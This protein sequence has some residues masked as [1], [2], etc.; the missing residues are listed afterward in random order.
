M[1]TLKT[2]LSFSTSKLRPP[3]I[4]TFKFIWQQCSTASHYNYWRDSMFPWQY[5]S[6]GMFFKILNFLDAT[7][8]FYTVVAFL[9]RFWSFLSKFRLFAVFFSL[10]SI[11]LLW[12]WKNNGARNIRRVGLGQD[13]RGA[14][15]TRNSAC[16]NP[17]LL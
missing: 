5:D 12:N 17:C 9:Y 13:E 14:R 16:L 8:H 1:L 15:P 2:F 3:N 7:L 11:I 10:F 6:D 4:V